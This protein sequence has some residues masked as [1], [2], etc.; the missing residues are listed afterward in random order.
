MEAWWRALVQVQVA[1]GRLA[2]VHGNVRLVEEVWKAVP[3]VAEGEGGGP[4][5]GLLGRQRSDPWVDYAAVQAEAVPHQG[6]AVQPHG[7]QGR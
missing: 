7:G 3:V 4:L 2:P 6:I 5:V 1:V